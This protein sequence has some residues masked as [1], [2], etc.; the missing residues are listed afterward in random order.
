MPKEVEEYL[1]KRIKLFI[2]EGKRVAP[3]NHDILYLPIHEGGKDLLSIK[4]RN[5]AIEAKLLRDYLT[6][7]GDDR[8]RWC[9]LADRRFTREVPT[10]VTVNKKIRE[11]P[12][13]QTW[14]PLQ[15][16]LPK[17][18]KRM[19]KSARKL[20]LKFDALALSKDIKN[21]LPV[22]FHI[23]GK[24][25]L[26]KKNN[27]GCAKCLRDNHGVRSTGDALKI[28]ERN[29]HH[30][31]RRRNCACGPCR[32]DRLIGCEIPYKCQ[33]EAVKILDCIYEKWDPRAPV[34]QTNPE[35][36]L[37]EVEKNVQALEDD[38]AVIFD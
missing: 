31:S 3:I 37:E 30:H 38:E 11:S 6:R 23:G 1:D 13:K 26:A 10:G 36:L 12:F 28:V 21:E 27:S 19:Y 7:E 34:R 35:L 33:E 16:S 8:P 15:K 25:A 2:W 22:F 4:D 24:K 9:N 18:L 5:E 17:P 32:S 29:Y 14:C 20:R